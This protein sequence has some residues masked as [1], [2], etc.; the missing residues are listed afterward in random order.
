LELSALY[1]DARAG[2]IPPSEATRLA[3]VVR[4]IADLLEIERIE[5][6]LDELER[7]AESLPANSRTVG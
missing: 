1:R 3:Y 2:R 4:Q 7:R 6:R 5:L